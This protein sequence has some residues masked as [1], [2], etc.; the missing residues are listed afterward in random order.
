MSNEKT[1]KEMQSDERIH[2]HLRTEGHGVYLFDQYGRRLGSV[3]SQQINTKFGDVIS[4]TVTI[5]L[6]S[7]ES[8]VGGKRVCATHH[9]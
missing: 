9:P 1:V 5:E 8:E 3:C 4:A 6:S 2:L 7:P